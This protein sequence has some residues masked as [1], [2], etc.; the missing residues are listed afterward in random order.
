MF[1]PDPIDKD[2]V[3]YTH[4]LALPNNQ[5]LFVDGARARHSGARVALQGPCE[6][7]VCG[8][9]CTEGDLVG[10]CNRFGQCVEPPV[11]C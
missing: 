1:R 2:F 8:E 5:D 3:P 6:N 9:R 4:R 11:R 10:V 7:K